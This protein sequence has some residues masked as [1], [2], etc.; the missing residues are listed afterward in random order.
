[1]I[2]RWKPGRWLGVPAQIAGDRIET[3]RSERGRVHAADLVDDARPDDA[4]LH[5]CFEW[6]DSTAAE[7]YRVSQARAVLESL[8]V[9]PVEAPESDPVR[10]FIAVGDSNHPNDFQPLS[11]VMSDEELRKKALRAA[12]EEL[13]RAK[14]R[15]AHLRE[16]AEVWK[17][18]AA[19]PVQ[20]VA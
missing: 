3:I 10:A 13:N 1:M 9:V 17:A 7:K 6:D 15:Y 16:L 2:Y 8:V 4:P 5:P 14:A 20:A 18:L 12:L 19:I 11:V